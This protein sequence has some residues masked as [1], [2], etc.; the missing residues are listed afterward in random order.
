MNTL[1]TGWLATLLLVIALSACNPTNNPATPAQDTKADP[2]ESNLVI[3]EQGSANGS[4]I[5]VRDKI[6]GVRVI[7]WYNGGTVVLERPQPLEGH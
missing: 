5:I 1:R 7:N 2:K 4:Y 3:E 6:S